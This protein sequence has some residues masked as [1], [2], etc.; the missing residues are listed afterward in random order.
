MLSLLIRRIKSVKG[1]SVKTGRK[2]VVH[3]R[4][5]R[6]QHCTAGGKNMHASSTSK[7]N[8]SVKYEVYAIQRVE[9]LLN[10]RP[11]KRLGWKTPYQVFY[12]R[13]G[14]ALEG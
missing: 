13:T 11:R 6:I 9:Y 8:T 14:V 3:P 5:S 1:G 7:C 12:E 2:F 10:S 4:I